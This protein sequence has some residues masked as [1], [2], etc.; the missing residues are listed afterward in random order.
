[1]TEE[2]KFTEELMRKQQ[3]HLLQRRRIT[4]AADLHADSI[5]RGEALCNDYDR[6]T[7]VQMNEMQKDKI[8]LDDVDVELQYLQDELVNFKERQRKQLE[9][10]R[11]K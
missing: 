6:E 9:E 11:R 4:N 10:D 3:E 1:M 8:K 5:K 2:A 7:Q